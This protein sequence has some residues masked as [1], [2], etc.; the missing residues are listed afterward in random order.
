MKLNKIERAKANLSP[1][2]YYNRLDSIN[3]TNINDI[4]R[5]YLK[6]F[7]IY[8]QKP[9]EDFF[10][11]IRIAGGRVAIKDLE[12]LLSVAK[13]F[14]AKIVFTARAQIELQN[15]NAS[16]VL[17]AFRALEKMNLTS[18]QTLTDNF[19]NIVTDVYDGVLEDSKIETYETVLKLQKEVLKNP[20]ICWYVTA[21]I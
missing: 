8:N 18:W 1:I 11:R 17:S 10:I 5:F 6:N 12:N 7:G 14:N 16:N 19:R 9:R 20:K 3:F 13:E 15:L 21:Q 2:E 4:D